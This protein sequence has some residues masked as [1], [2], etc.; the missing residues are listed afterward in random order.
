MKPALYTN[1]L[2]NRKMKFDKNGNQLT[3]DAFQSLIS[4]EAQCSLHQPKNKSRDTQDDGHSIGCVGIRQKDRSN[5]LSR[6]RT[7][8]H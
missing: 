2:L 7:K 6:Q 3:Q 4:P 1:T 5:K 8:F